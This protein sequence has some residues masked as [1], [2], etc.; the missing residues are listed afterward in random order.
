LLDLCDLDTTV[1]EIAC[2]WHGGNYGRYDEQ[3]ANQ[4]AVRKLIALEGPRQGLAEF[5]PRG[6]RSLLFTNNPA[7]W[8]TV[9]K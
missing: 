6:D 7:E 2:N 5:S 9:T 4:L 3:S 1:V 8:P